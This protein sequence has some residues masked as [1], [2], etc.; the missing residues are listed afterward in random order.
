M[1]NCK[2]TNP[3][4]TN[5]VEETQTHTPNRQTTTVCGFFQAE[6]ANLLEN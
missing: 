5:S 2:H 1:A 3:G 6:L 4:E